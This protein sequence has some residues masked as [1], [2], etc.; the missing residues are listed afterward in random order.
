MFTFVGMCENAFN[1]LH[2]EVQI[3][4]K[5]KATD[6]I[7]YLKSI[8]STNHT[9]Y[10]CFILYVSSHGGRG[11]ICCSDFNPNKEVE[12]ATEREDQGYIWC[13]T[14]LE[15]FLY[16]NCTTLRGKPK[17]FF[18]DCYCNEDLTSKYDPSF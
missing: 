6:I 4:E 17:L 7:N 5:T 15:I 8:A 11:F 3:C 9:M 1:R 13:D 10:D 12:L 2:F 16:K 14:L 18:F